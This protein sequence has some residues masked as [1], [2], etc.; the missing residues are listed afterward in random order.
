[1]STTDARAPLDTEPWSINDMVKSATASIT[2]QPENAKPMTKNPFRIKPA[3]CDWYFFCQIWLC[4]IINELTYKRCHFSDICSRH[5]I[6]RQEAITDCWNYQ[7]ENDTQKMREA[8]K[9]SCGEK[10]KFLVNWHNEQILENVI[11]CLSFQSPSRARNGS[12][13]VLEQ[14][15]WKDPKRHPTGSKE[16]WL[17]RLFMD[18]CFSLCPYEKLVVLE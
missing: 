4:L 10:E 5:F 8:R 17:F 2:S 18:K 6:G 7:W 3:K 14:W 11:S 16:V 13:S 9:D 15:A 1:M 12:M